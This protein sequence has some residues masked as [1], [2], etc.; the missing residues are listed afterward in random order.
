MPWDRLLYFNAL[1]EAFA[2][3]PAIVADPTDVAGHILPLQPLRAGKYCLLVTAAT[4]PKPLK[5][6]VPT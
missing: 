3:D 4:Q 5:S 6:L 1:P 2:S